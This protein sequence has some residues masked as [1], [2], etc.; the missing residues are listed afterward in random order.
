VGT[1]FAVDLSPYRTFMIELARESGD[2]I[3]Q[4]YRAPGVAV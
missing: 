3:A 4:H 1:P 2:F